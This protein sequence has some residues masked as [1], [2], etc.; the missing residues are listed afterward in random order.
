M[1]LKK[2]PALFNKVNTTESEEKQKFN[3]KDP[4]HQVFQQKYNKL[5]SKQITNY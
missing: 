3:Q 2:N 1:N 4:N 5:L